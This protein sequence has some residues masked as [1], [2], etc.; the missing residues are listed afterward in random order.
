MCY[1]KNS[2]ALAPPARGALPVQRVPGEP[3][4][5]L[6]YCAG[7]G[8]DA[9]L[10]QQARAKDS[11]SAANSRDCPGSRGL[12]VS[13][14]SGAAEARGLEHREKGGVSAVSRRGPDAA[15]Q[16]A[17]ATLRSDESA[18]ASEADSAE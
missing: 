3:A 5:S 12:W 6:P 13:Q 8:I 17:T 15:L 7:R 10:S 2:E 11:S 1:Q 14:D 9:S 4:A 16:A 18:G